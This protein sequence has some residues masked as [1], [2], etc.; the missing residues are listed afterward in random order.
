M[1]L[2]VFNRVSLRIFHFLN[3]GDKPKANSEVAK[4]WHVIAAISRPTILLNYAPAAAT[5]HAVRPR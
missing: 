1:R 4:A 2:S 3:R 5:M